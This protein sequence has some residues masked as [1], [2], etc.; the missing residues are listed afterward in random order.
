MDQFRCGIIW[1]VSYFVDET[2]TKKLFSV[3]DPGIGDGWGV[4]EE[5]EEQG[6]TGYRVEWGQV[7]SVFKV[8]PSSPQKEALAEAWRMLSTK[9]PR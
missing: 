7:K 2:P 5:G 1:S 8:P 4:R 3:L 6:S 9:G